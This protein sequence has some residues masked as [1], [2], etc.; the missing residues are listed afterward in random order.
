MSRFSRLLL[1]TLMIVGLAGA[2]LPG[3]GQQVTVAA[4]FIGPIGDYGWSY[5]AHRDLTYLAEKHDWLD[6]LHAEAVPFPEA[7]GVIRDFIDKGATIIFAHSFGY[8]GTLFMLAEEFPHVKFHYPGGFE[9]MANVATY[10]WNEYEVRFVTG[11]L[12]GMMT[13]TNVLGFVGAHPILRLAWGINAYILGVQ[14]VNPDAEVRVI[15]SGAWYDPPREK[16]IAHSLIDLGADFITYHT[17]SPAAGIA[18]EGRGVYAFG[19][20][21]A[22]R[23]FA[24]EAAVTTALLNWTSLFEHLI[25]G[26]RDGTWE[27]GVFDWG[28]AEGTVDMAPLGDMV[29]PELRAWIEHLVLLIR[30]GYLVVPRIDDPLW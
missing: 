9:T 29:P 3:F 4:I 15:F 21:L 6:Y 1:V 5:V 28:L 23:P 24:P 2:I 13:Q 14:Q 27:T 25:K 7:E 18:A 16:E 30:E 10:Y 26:V 20:A 12:S 11:V 8:K 22:L 17:D 19:K